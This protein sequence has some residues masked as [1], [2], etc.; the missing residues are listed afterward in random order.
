MINQITGQ[1]NVHYVE[2]YPY[3]FRLRTTIRYWIETRPGYGQRSASQT[4]NP[5]KPGEVWNAP[6]YS[7]Y[8]AII[9]MYLEYDETIQKEKVK[10]WHLSHTAWAESITEF[11]NQNFVLSD[12]QKEQLRRVKVLNETVKSGKYVITPSDITILVDKK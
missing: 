1:D 9:I 11:E 12:Y 8:S 3:G 10:F 7:T 2:D 4:R 5:K 6:K